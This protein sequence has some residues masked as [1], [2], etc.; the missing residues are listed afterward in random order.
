M[1]DLKKTV[2][3]ECVKVDGKHYRIHT[4]FKYWLMF[5]ELT[6][7]GCSVHDLDFIYM[8]EKP[9][10]R[11]AGVAAMLEFC[12]PPREIPRK[13]KDGGNGGRVLDYAIDSDMIYSA[14]LEQYGIDLVESDLH[15]HKFNALMF[16]L[17]GTRLNSVIEY[18]CYSNDGKRSEYSDHMEEMKRIWELP[19]RAE[20][21]DE[22]LKAFDSLFK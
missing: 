6:E 11:S 21:C 5:L 20:E 1:I 4:S 13:M 10:D 3:P 14:F 7:G 12:N 9:D 19:D 8:D 18:R 2:L 16:G 22:E 17:H 15:W